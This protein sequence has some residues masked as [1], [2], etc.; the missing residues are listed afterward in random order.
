M[1]CH[2][3]AHEDRGL[4]GTFLVLEGNFIQFS[5][6]WNSKNFYLICKS[7]S[8]KEWNRFRPD[9]RSKTDDWGD[10]FGIDI[11]EDVQLD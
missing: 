8:K 1:H 5:Y 6:D 10:I 2:M 4:M 3:L 7:I 11:F 9:S